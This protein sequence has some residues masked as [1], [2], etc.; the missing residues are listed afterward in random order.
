MQETMLHL[1]TNPPIPTMANPLT[2]TAPKL[3]NRDP[4]EGS[5]SPL[6]PRPRAPLRRR[7]LRWKASGPM[8]CALAP[9]FLS[10]SACF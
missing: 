8:P 4:K 6:I 9:L 7:L 2:G 5:S 3:V 1:L 10:S